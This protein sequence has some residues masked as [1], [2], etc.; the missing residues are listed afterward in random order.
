MADLLFE[1]SIS[2]ERRKP[3]DIDVDFE[4]ERREEMIKYVY[5]KYGRDHTGLA[6]TG[7]PTSPRRPCRW[8]NMSSMITDRWQC[9]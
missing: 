8:A 4:H 6:E 3:P 2:P 1:R 9:R 7:S 5:K